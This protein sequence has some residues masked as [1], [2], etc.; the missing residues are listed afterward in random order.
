MGYEPRAAVMSAP[1]ARIPSSYSS[2]ATWEGT[3]DRSDPISAAARPCQEQLKSSSS[4]DTDLPSRVFAASS[5]DQRRKA[6]VLCEF[7]NAPVVASSG[8]V[9][10]AAAAVAGLPVRSKGVQLVW[11]RRSHQHVNM[12]TVMLPLAQQCT[13]IVLQQIRDRVS[14]KL[15]V[16]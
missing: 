11:L 7:Y 5:P 16:H 2:E 12:G 4:P 10:L 9:P 8:S 14:L 13:S 1:A 6:M 3:Y 15:L